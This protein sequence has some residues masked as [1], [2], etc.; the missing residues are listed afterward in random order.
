MEYNDRQR[1]HSKPS[2]PTL[3][4]T[5]SPVYH[6]EKRR[7]HSKA[8]YSPTREVNAGRSVHHAMPPFLQYSSTTSSKSPVFQHSRDPNNSS[9]S[10]ASKSRHL[11]NHHH[12]RK[13]SFFEQQRD[14]GSVDV[15]HS[16]ESKLS[17]ISDST[18]AK[19]KMLKFLIHE[20]RGLKNELDPPSPSE[21]HA[22]S[23]SFSGQRQP[24]H[25]TA[26]HP[27]RSGTPDGSF[28]RI[29]PL[30]AKSERMASLLSRPKSTNFVRISSPGALIPAKVDQCHHRSLIKEYLGRTSIKLGPLSKQEKEFAYLLI[31]LLK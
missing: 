14:D 4:R 8:A 13:H 10:D 20:V 3:E 11:E 30:L 1:R 2:T 22:R 19:E 25:H 21:K 24:V 31:S 12:Q 5:S 6:E 28:E 15:S 29:T 23:G 7:R 18:D 27:K 17:G 26:Q 9:R 16:V